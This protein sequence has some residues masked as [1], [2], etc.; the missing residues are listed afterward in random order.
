[1]RKIATCF[2]AG[3]AVALAP[4]AALAAPVKLVSTL[5]G[6][7]ETAGGDTDGSGTFSVELDTETGDVC[8]VLTVA[9]IAK[10][11]AAHVHEGA[12]GADGKPVMTLEV[13]GPDSDMCLAAEPDLLKLIEATPGGYYVNVHTADF[14][15]GAV[16]GQLAAKP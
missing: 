7:G 1:M 12:A 2:I 11:V 5:S 13:T 8:Y 4:S 16:R 14:P 9:N 10:P 3:A 15:K 6:A